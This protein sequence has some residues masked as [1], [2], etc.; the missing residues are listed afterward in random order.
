MWKF[1]EHQ[2]RNVRREHKASNPIVSDDG[3]YI[4]FQRARSADMPGV[5]RGLFLY[6][7]SKAPK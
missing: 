5:G 6:D 2:D 7:I 3:R 1:A 4:A